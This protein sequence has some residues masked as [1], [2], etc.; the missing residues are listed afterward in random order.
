MFGLAE[1]L[2]EIWLPDCDT[3]ILLDHHTPALHLI[4]RIRDEAHR[5]AITHHRSLRGKA[6]IHSS[7]EDIPGIGPKR[8]KAL[9][10]KLGS[11]KAIKEATEEQLLAVPGMNKAAAQAV[12]KWAE[13]TKQST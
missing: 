5:F 10:T 8:R 2:E 3:P 9:L 7:L 6:A 1:R 11:L 12:L 4:Q 13:H